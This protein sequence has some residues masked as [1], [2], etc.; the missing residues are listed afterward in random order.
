[1]SICSPTP[2]MKE[3]SNSLSIWPEYKHW[4]YSPNY[5]SKLWILEVVRLLLQGVGLLVCTITRKDMIFPCA[6]QPE[7]SLQIYC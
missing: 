6:L 2:K 4:K 3:I 7:L 5:L 1:M